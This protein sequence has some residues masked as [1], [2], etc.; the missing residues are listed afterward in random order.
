MLGFCLILFQRALP[1]RLDRWDLTNTQIN[2]HKNDLE[3]M[4]YCVHVWKL[5]HPKSRNQDGQRL[6]TPK[7]A[8]QK[9]LFTIKRACRHCIAWREVSIGW[10]SSSLRLLGGEDVVAIEVACRR[11]I[12][13]GD[14]ICFCIY[15]HFI[16]HMIIG[17]LLLI[18]YNMDIIN[19]S[20]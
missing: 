6:W 15:K 16:K 18:I 12:A 19:L 1:E 9:M 5:H 20:S 2:T 13:K 17:V 7:E 3:W 8:K 14:F 10:L 4:N 11:C